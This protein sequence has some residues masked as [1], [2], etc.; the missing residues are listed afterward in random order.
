ML[1]RPL[2]RKLG[3]FSDWRAGYRRSLGVSVLSAT[4]R[5]SGRRAVISVRLRAR[6][7]DACREGS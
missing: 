4:A 7:R 1:A 2:R 5:L 6:D 3:P